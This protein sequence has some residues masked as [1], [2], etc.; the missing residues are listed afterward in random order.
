[1]H[2]DKEPDRRFNL[3]EF[4]AITHAIATY[5]DLN[6]LTNHLAEGTARTF[7]AKGC[8]IMLLDEREKQLFPI[9]SYGLSDEYIKKGPVMVDKQ[10][11]AFCTGEPVFI[12]DIQNDPRIQ[13][14]KAAAKEGLIS[15]LSVPIKYRAEVVGIIR[16]YLPDG[17]PIHESDVDSLLVL[18]E[19]LGLVIEINGLRNFLD[20]VKMALENLPLR[21]LE[22]L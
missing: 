18:A 15:M 17:A 13:Y 8:S 14:P 22:G 5:E 11:C 21:M 1:M 16:I 9:S 6:L 10:Y 19:Q 3:R 20:A 2:S 12:E 7:R 4:K